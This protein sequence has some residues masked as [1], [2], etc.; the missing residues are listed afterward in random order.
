MVLSRYRGYAD[1]GHYR[2]ARRKQ[3]RAGGLCF[4]VKTALLG[5]LLRVRNWNWF[6]GV[7]LAI[8]KT[9]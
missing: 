2:A 5:A 3:G 4:G 1:I 8:Q 6:A 7:R 9:A